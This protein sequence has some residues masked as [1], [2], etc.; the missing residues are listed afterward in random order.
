MKESSNLSFKYS[1]VFLMFP[2]FINLLQNTWIDQFITRT[3]LTLIL[4][5]N[6]TV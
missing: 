3:I 4:Y 6:A 2:E 1:K 5:K